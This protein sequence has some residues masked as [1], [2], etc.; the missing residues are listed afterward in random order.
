MRIKHSIVWNDLMILTFFQ[1]HQP[2]PDIRSIELHTRRMSRPQV[3]DVLSDYLCEFK[4]NACIHVYPSRKYDVCATH[5]CALRM[6][7]WTYAVLLNPYTL[8]EQSRGRLH[9][10]NPTTE[11]LGEYMETP[12][13]TNYLQRLSAWLFDSHSQP[14]TYCNIITYMCIHFV[15][16]IYSHQIICCWNISSRE[17]DGECNLRDG[18]LW[19]Q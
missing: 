19:V 6:H 13:N 16:H 10:C 9:T 5:A 14:N 4:N 1:H 7:A 12:V 11:K 3:S 2:G 15:I 8:T 17:K 18:L